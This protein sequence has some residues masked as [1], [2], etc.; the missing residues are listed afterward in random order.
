MTARPPMIQ[1]LT[2][3]VISAHPS[4]SKWCCKGAIRK[5]RLPFES[6]K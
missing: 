4:S 5:I 6:L 1:N 3:I 2:T